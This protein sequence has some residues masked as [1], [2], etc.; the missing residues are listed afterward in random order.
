ME[1][2]GDIFARTIEAIGGPIVVLIFAWFMVDRAGDWIRGKSKKWLAAT[3]IGFALLLGLH[4]AATELGSLSAQEQAEL[5]APVRFVLGMFYYGPGR[6][7][8]VIAGIF[9]IIAGAV[10]PMA[11]DHVIPEFM[12]RKKEGGSS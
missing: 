8:Y 5:A 3:L 2:I 1:N 6:A 7:G 10:A 12:K 4:F 11:H 9:G